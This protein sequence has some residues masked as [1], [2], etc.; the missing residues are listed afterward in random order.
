MKTGVLQNKQDFYTPW[1]KA[2]HKR[3]VW[4]T[5]YNSFRVSEMETEHIKSCLTMLS[6]RHF[7]GHKQ[8]G[9]YMTNGT[10]LNEEYVMCSKLSKW[11]DI[12]EYELELRNESKM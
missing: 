9:M 2:E 11:I 6:K 5:P 3:A 4:K 10:D 12:F 7:V 1:V 8:L